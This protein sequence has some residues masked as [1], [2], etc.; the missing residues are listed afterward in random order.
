MVHTRNLVHNINRE[1]Q[2]GEHRTDILSLK[3]ERKIDGGTQN[4]AHGI[5][6]GIQETLRNCRGH[7]AERL[8]LIE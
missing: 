8:E 2:N 5:D 6:R 7:L 1:R 4:L 3:W